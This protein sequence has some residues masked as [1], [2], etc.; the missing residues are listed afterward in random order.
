M[1]K[2]KFFKFLV[3][4]VILT[5]PTLVQAAICRFNNPNLAFGIY[6]PRPGA[7]NTSTATITVVCSDMKSDVPYS[8]SLVKTKQFLTMTKGGDIIN[9][10]LFTTA[11]YTTTWDDKNVIKGVVVNNSGNGFD[12]KTV[13]SKIIPNQSGIKSGAYTS[14]ADPV[15]ITLNYTQ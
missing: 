10:Q 8:L 11:S 14:F 4:L 15:I 6:D 5:F 12:T 2:L 9:Y 1:F 13:Y 7:S 3:I